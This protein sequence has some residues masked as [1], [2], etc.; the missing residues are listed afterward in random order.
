MIARIEQVA[1]AETDKM[2]FALLANSNQANWP[3]LREA[4]R[5]SLPSPLRP[6]Y[7]SSSP[8]IDAHRIFCDQLAN[9]EDGDAP[10]IGVISFR[11]MRERVTLT[12]QYK[13][14]EVELG[15]SNLPLLVI[16]PGGTIMPESALL[17]GRPVESI[18][19]PMSIGRVIAALKR[20]LGEP[21]AR[22]ELAINSSG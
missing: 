16:S 7:V 18:S 3:Q 17:D 5:Q 1:R 19:T 20:L 13:A 11:Q 21:V 12:A 10:N 6:L 15:L 8:A 22:D 14:K 9:W 4:H 2:H